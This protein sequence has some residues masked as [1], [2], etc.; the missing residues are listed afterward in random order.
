[1]IDRVLDISDR[2]AKLHVRNDQLVIEPEGGEPVSAPLAEIAAL[3]VSHPRVSYTHSVLDGLARA[4]A[5]LVVCDQKHLPSAMLLP[6]AGHYVQAER[7]GAQA[8]APLPLK[9]RL[10]AEIVKAKVANQ[11]RLLRLLL[12]NDHG[13]VAL[14]RRVRSGD[15]DNLEAQAARRYFEALFGKKFKRDREADDHN[16]NLNYGYAVVRAA[17]ARAICAAGLHPSLGLH[18]HNRYDAFCLADDL[19]EPFRPLNDLA[20]FLWLKTAGPDAPFDLEAKRAILRGL[21][22]QFQVD[23]ERRSLFDLAGRAAS[24][25]AHVFIGKR[26]KLALPELWTEPG[27]PMPTG[28]EDEEEF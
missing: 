14:S 10:W 8:E 19:M 13:L 16:R 9:K 28:E 6:L 25:L 1:M 22:D 24:S 27:K 7:I 11:G 15:P 3:V 18:H 21:A 17:V 2:P 26:K 20:V 5:A 4:G 12:K 23:G